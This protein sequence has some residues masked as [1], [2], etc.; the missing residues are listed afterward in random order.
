MIQGAVLVVALGIG[1][2][3]TIGMYLHVHYTCGGDKEFAS[4]IGGFGGTL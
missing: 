1:I 2:D 3:A 4:V